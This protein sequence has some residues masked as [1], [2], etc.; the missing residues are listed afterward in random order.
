MQQHLGFTYC[1]SHIASS[2][3]SP[4]NLQALRLEFCTAANTID[5]MRA[6]AVDYN[7]EQVQRAG[8]SWFISVEEVD[9]FE[10][11]AALSSQFGRC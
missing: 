4:L 11:P 5:Q 2:F 6:I 7:E 10:R 3:I 9:E 8:V 1:V